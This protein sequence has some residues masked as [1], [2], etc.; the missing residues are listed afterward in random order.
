MHTEKLTQ[1]SHCIQYTSFTTYEG[2]RTVFQQVHALP[3]ILP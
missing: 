3:A 1:T 2:N